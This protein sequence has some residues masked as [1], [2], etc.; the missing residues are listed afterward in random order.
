MNFSIDPE[1]ESEWNCFESS[2][3]LHWLPTRICALSSLVHPLQT[4]MAS[5]ERTELSSSTQTTR[6]YSACWKTM[7]RAVAQ[8]SM[9]SLIGA[10]LFSRWT[11]PRPKA[12]SLTFSKQYCQSRGSSLKGLCENTYKYLGIGINSNFE[13]NCEPAQKRTPAPVL[14]EK[15]L[16]SFNIDNAMLTFTKS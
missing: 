8:S 9:I 14:L 7:T 1:S 11:R 4:C 15:K 16:S 12:W 10:S 5:A 2:Y 3:I 6:L 13:A